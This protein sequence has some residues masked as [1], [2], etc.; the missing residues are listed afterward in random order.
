[1]HNSRAIII[2][3]TYSLKNTTL[4]KIPAI[5]HVSR[6]LSST[7]SATVRFRR[8]GT[9][10]A[11]QLVSRERLAAPKCA[12]SAVLYPTVPVSPVFVFFEC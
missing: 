1:M 4:K 2:D 11:N 12:S 5:Q 10:C 7:D 3:Y 8:P 6:Y 9:H